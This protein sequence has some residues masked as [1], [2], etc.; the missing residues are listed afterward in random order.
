MGSGSFRDVL[1]GYCVN[2]V[3]FVYKD[4]DK[5]MGEGFCGQFE[6]IDVELTLMESPYIP[7]RYNE[8]IKQVAPYLKDDFDVGAINPLD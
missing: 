3:E 1:I 4:E 5:E 6:E 7:E 8:I 2:C